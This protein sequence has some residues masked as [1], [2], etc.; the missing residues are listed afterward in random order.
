MRLCRFEIRDEIG[1]G[2][3]DDNRVLPLSRAAE[4]WG[5]DGQVL[6]SASLL[7]MLPPDGKRHATVRQLYDWVQ[8]AG[9]AALASSWIATSEVRLKPPIPDPPKLF[10]L[11]GNYAAHIE[12]GGGK[13]VERAE[14]FPYV[15][16]KPPST[17]LNDPGGTFQLPPVSPHSLDYELELAVVLGRKAKG[18][19]AKEALDYVAGYVVVND[20]S[21]RKFRPNPHRKERSRDTF[22]DWQHGKWHDGSCPCGPCITSAHDIPNPQQLDMRLT[23]NGEIRQNAS[24]SLQVFTVAEVIEFLSSFVTLEPGDIISTGTC[25]GV[26]GPQGIFLKPGDCVE[27]T[28]AGIGTLVTNVR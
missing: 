4:A 8:G 7:E 28:I 21:D 11:A 1:V 2:F 25:A 19:S 12:E 9:R 3:Y 23:V 24:T 13:A 14:T 15:F 10:L 5:G 17:T 26:G 20:I 18:V 22:F 6:P 16:M 27:A